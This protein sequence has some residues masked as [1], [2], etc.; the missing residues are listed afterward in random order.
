[1]LSQRAGG[2]EA[3]SLIQHQL[4]A[5][6]ERLRSGPSTAYE[7]LTLSAL[8]DRRPIATRYEVSLVLA[9]LRYLERVGRLH[10]LETEDRIQYAVA[11]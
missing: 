11:A 9:R 7:L 1:M 8:R 2:R 4:E 6:V 10:R 3:F 5:I